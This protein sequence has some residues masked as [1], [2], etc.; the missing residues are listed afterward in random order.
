MPQG[1]GTYGSKVGRP[2]NP[3]KQRKLKDLVESGKKYK[4]VVTPDKQRKLKKLGEAIK[5]GASAGGVR[6][7]EK[8]PGYKK[9]QDYAKKSS[10]TLGSGGYKEEASRVNDARN[11][12]KKTY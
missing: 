2:S 1:K 7:A 9:A 5:I 4:K 10:A 12:S 3:K 8:K 6:K 11:R